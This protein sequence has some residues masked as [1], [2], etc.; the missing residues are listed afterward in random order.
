MNLNKLINTEA[1]EPRDAIE[2]GTTFLK[3]AFE[4]LKQAIDYEENLNEGF[5]K[6]LGLCLD[7]LD[8]GEEAIDALKIAVSINPNYVE[9]HSDLG[10]YC[11]FSGKYE[12]AIKSYNELLRLRPNDVDAYGRLGDSYVELGLYEQAIEAC[13]KG[14]QIHPNDHGLLYGLGLTYLRMGKIGPAIRIYSELAAK[15]EFLAQHLLDQI[16]KTTQ[17]GGIQHDNGEIQPTTS[18]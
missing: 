5:F 12:E 7:Q 10:D 17:K 3:A 1:Q 14:I 8:L 11:Y 13:K 6:S 2:K 9:A 16:E 15:D 4:L 18:T